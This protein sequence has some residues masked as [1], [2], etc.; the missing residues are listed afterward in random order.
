MNINVL[1][2][3]DWYNDSIDNNN[4]NSSM[5]MNGID[6]TR[7]ICNNALNEREQVN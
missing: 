4:N 1:L 7:G 3:D 2:V 5:Y 6:W